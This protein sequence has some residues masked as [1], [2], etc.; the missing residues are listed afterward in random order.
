MALPN[1]KINK[2]KLPGTDNTYEIIPTRL[3]SVNGNDKY[4]VSVPTVSAN[5]T[6]VT[7]V[8]GTAPD[9]SGNVS[10]EGS[11]EISGGS[12]TSWSEKT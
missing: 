9:A 11:I 7:S 1:K 3:Q 2:V 6:L 12:S 5:S 10:V 4:E 8:N